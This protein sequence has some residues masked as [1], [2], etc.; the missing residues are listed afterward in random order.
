MSARRAKSRLTAGR[1]R[2]RAQ[3]L[4][5]IARKIQDDVWS[6]VRGSETDLGWADGFPTHSRA[7]GPAFCSIY[8][9]RKGL[10]DAAKTPH[11]HLESSSILLFLLF[12]PQ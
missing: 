4:G 6:V 2:R 3:K 11:P 7:S 8:H 9:Y 10:S 1:S 5:W 12:H